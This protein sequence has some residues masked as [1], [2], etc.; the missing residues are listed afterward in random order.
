MR[1]GPRKPSDGDQS[2]AR[3]A[4]SQQDKAESG[5]LVGAQ[6]AKDD[7]AGPD[8]TSRIHAPSSANLRAT[9][10]NS[11]SLARNA[12]TTSGSNCAPEWRR[13][14]SRASSRESASL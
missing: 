8:S 2:P 11:A 1:P 14:Y 4:H 6:D 5:T 9:S 12:A 13:M 7:V 3:I 10:T